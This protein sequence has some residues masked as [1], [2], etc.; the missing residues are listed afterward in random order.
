MFDH[1][2]GNDDVE[3]GIGERQTAAIA[4]GQANV[5][6]PVFELCGEEGLT[7]IIKA[8]NAVGRAGEPGRA[9]ADSASRIEH[10]FAGDERLGKAIASEMLVH[11]VDVGLTGYYPLAGKL[12]HWSASP[13][14]SRAFGRPALN[15][16][17]L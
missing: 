17:C 14:S 5:G 10:T 7:C 13:L 11:Q 8:D 6:V 1:L 12:H 3:T 15:R 4:F 9:V 2:K 16:L